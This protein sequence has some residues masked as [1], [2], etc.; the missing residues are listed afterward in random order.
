MSNF[1]ILHYSITVRTL[2]A[3]IQWTE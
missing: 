3:R 1:L 2:D